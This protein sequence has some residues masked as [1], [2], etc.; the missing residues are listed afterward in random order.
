ML[1]TCL[2]CVTHAL[3]H[4]FF[5][6]FNRSTIY[7]GLCAL[8]VLISS[9]K[10]PIH[11]DRFTTVALLYTT[12]LAVV[13]NISIL[14]HSIATTKLP[15]VHPVSSKMCYQVVERYSVCRCLYYKHAIDPCP[16]HGQ[17]GHTVQ[18]KTVL[19]GYACSSH[20]NHRP[21]VSYNAG[22]LPDSGYGSGTFPPAFLR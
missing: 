18:E 1:E 9:H 8:V 12:C 3:V 17:R 7:L 2:P 6:V 16:A 4:A 15:P 21:E 11:I 22:V 13:L 5:F 20:S 19:V 10:S 14:F